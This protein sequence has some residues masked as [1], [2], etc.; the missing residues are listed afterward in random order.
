MSTFNRLKSCD[1]ISFYTLLSY[2]GIRAYLFSPN[3]GS[4]YVFSIRNSC[5]EFLASYGVIFK[6]II[7]PFFKT[8]VFGAP[9][10]YTKSVVKD[11]V[12]EYESNHYL[13]ILLIFIIILPV[14]FIV[15][16]S[17]EMTNYVA[18]FK[19]LIKVTYTSA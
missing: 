4:R 15:C 19:F 10:S 9:L 17:M 14:F 8:P 11:I 5:C 16:I 7:K 13:R 18:Q 12:T 6:S 3:E 2:F 1:G